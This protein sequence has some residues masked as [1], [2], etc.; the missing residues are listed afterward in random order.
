LAMLWVVAAIAPPRTRI[1]GR[2]KC[3]RFQPL[4]G[5]R[6]RYARNGMVLIERNARND[7]CELRSTAMRTWHSKNESWPRWERG[8]ERK[9]VVTVPKTL[10]GIANVTAI[11]IADS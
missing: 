4:D 6:L 3:V 1:N 2:Y 7:T 10:G 11:G 5:A 8:T 9:Q